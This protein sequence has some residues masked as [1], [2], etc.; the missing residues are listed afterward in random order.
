MP[1][2][3]ICD[4]ELKPHNIRNKTTPPA[5]LIGAKPKTRHFSIIEIGRGVVLVYWKKL[6]TKI[7]FRDSHEIFCCKFCFFRDP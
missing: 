2:N 7:G 6:I 3:A 1:H 4:I 5:E